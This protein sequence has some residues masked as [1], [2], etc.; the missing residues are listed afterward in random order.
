[1]YLA[2]GGGG[3]APA[4]Q[5]TGTQTLHVEPSAIPEALKA[6]TDAHD[7]VTAKIRELH[8]LPITD[9][10]G[11][12]VS[13]ETAI[14]FQ[15][16]SNRRGADSALACLEGYEKQLLAAINSLK[17]AQADYLRIEGDNT[18][19]WGKYHRD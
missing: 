6:F 3:S 11:D 19:V 17:G 1:M 14:E 9:W 18:D 4:P 5:F 2:E 10:A 8:A 15:Q 7:R 13:S 12:P 16:R